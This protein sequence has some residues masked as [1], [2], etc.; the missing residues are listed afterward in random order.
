M[1]DGNILVDG[2]VMDNYPV[3]TLQTLSESS[4]V[5]GVNISPYEEHLPIYDYDTSLSGWRV[6]MN[7]CPR[8]RYRRGSCGKRVT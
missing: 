5:I 8:C 4:R 7:R 6:L 2:G 1:E 3:E